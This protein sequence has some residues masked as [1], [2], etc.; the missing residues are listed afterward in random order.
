MGKTTCLISICR[1][2]LGQG[3]R[4]I[5]FSYHQ[6]IDERLEGIVPSVKFV[7]FHGLGFNPLGVID[8]QSR[9]AYLDVSGAMRDIFVAIFPELGDIQ[10]ERIRKAIK[11]SFVERGW[12]NPAQQAVAPTEPQFKRFLEILRTDSKPDRGMRALLARLDELDDYGFFD[13][14]ESRDSL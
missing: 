7:D 3:V 8:R 1:Q 5:V 11:D 9:L 13:V 10:G 4:P 2:M 12:D 14:T 6:D